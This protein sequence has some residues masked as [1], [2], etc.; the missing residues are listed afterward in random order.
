MNIY[1]T[2]METGNVP[3]V[4]TAAYLAKSVIYNNREKLLASLIVAGWDKYKGGQV[5]VV[6]ISGMIV[7]KNFYISG[8]GSIYPMGYLD[9]T[10]RPNMPKEECLE[11]VKKAVAMAI[12]RDGSSGGCIRYAIIN[13]DGVEKSFIINTEL[14]RFFES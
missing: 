9:A 3:T 2:R 4:N 11:M 13:K 6:P 7:R 14:P 12:A 8:S 5:Y 1:F 10:F